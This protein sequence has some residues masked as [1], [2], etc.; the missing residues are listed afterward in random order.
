V[1]TQ[2]VVFWVMTPCSD[3]VRYQRFGEPCSGLRPLAC[4]DSEFNFWN[5]WIYFWTFGRTPWT[6]DQPVARPLPT[7]VST[8]QKRRGYTSMLRVGFEPKIPMFERL[9]TLCALDRPQLFTPRKRAPCTRWIGDWA[10][11]R[12]GLGAVVKSKI[13]SPCRDT[14]HRSSSP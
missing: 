13:P 12:A 14:N 4:F 11:P 9:K 1:R 6:G 7:Q 2:L 8:T 5:L 10:G 3:V